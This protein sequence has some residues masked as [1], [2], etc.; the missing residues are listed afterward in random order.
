LL[1]AN[2]WQLKNQFN[3]FKM[4]GKRYIILSVLF[5]C[6]FLL[7]NCNSAR[8]LSGT[9]KAK[10]VGGICGY[11]IIEILDSNFYRLGI[12]WKNSEGKQYQHV[13]AV[14]NHCDFVKAQLQTG[15]VFNCEIIEKAIEENCM[16]CEAYME[17]PELK[18]NVKVIQ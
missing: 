1:N 2:Y 16:T 4:S 7:A 14:N 10:L 11:H 6:S 5:F 17:T 12:S 13:F 15:D 3:S 9:F 18:R 8:Q